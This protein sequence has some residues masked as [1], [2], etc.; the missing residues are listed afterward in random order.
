MESINVFC[1]EVRGF[2]CVSCDVY[3]KPLPAEWVNAQVET[4]V[5]S[6]SR[7]LFK[8]LLPHGAW[9]IEANP[10]IIPAS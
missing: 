10:A 5:W 8:M 1:R 2:C 4:I 7:L 6:L 9:V 3:K